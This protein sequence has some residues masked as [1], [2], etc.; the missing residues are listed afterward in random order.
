MHNLHRYIH[1]IEGTS[2][3]NSNSKKMVNSIFES[4]VLLLFFFLGWLST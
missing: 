1:E 2:H 3:M 4:Q